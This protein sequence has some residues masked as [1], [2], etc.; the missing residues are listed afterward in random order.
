MKKFLVLIALLI[1]PLTAMAG[2]AVEDIKNESEQQI[3]RAMGNTSSSLEQAFE[4]FKNDPVGQTKV[5]WND[6]KVIFWDLVAASKNAYEELKR[7]V[8]S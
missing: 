2:N 8:G 6:A 7:K 4:N 5:Y 1:L 3:N